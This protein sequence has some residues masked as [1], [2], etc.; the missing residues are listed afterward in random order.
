MT[1]ALALARMRALLN[2]ADAALAIGQ[3]P[4]AAETAELADLVDYFD[5]WLDWIRS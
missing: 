2:A 1:A 4:S 5:A 3:Q